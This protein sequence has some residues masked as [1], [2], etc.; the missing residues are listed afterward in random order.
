MKQGLFRKALPHLIAIALFI[1]IALIYCKPALDGQV[2]QQSDI[3]I[4]KGAVQQSINYAALHDGQYPLWTNALLG[5]MPTFQIGYPSNNFI[6]GI[7][8]TIMTLNLPAPISYFFLACISFYILSIILKVNPYV[9]IMGSLAFAYATYNP[10]IISVGHLTKMMTMA[11]MPALLGSILLIY[12]KKYWLGAALTALFS[13]TM[14]TENH[15]Q[16]AYYFFIMVAIMTVFYV[17]SWIKAK[18]FSHLAK[19]IG[20][21]AIAAMVGVGTTAVNVMSTFEYQEATTRGGHTALTDTTSKEQSPKNGLSRSYGLSYSLDIPET[22][23]LMVPHMYG[24]SSDH[25]EVAQDES[26]AVE[27]LMTM[28][29]ELQQQLPLR[30][31]W[32]GISNSSGM[33]YT[34]GPPYA[35]AIICFLAIIAFFIIDKRYKWWIG[36]AL[37]VTIMMAW[38][39]H[40]GALNNF[41]FDHLPLYNKFRAPSM[42][43]VIPQLLLP[44]LAILGVN[45]FITTADKKAL[46]PGFKKG[47]IATGAVFI[48]LFLIY[49]S[50]SFMGKNDSDILKQVRESNNP[51]LVQT[52]KPFFDGLVDDRKGLFMDSLLRSLGFIAVAFIS[53]FL[54]TRNKLNGMWAAILL[55]AFVFLDL[56]LV[57]N[58]YLNKESFIEPSDNESVFNRNAIDNE[59]LADTSF[60]RVADLSGNNNIASYH[61]NTVGGFHAAGLSLY[62]DL[63]YR[64]VDPEQ[65]AIIQ[66]LQTT[67]TT[68]SVNTPVLN[69]LNAKYFIYRDNKETKAKWLN[70]NALGNCWFVSSIQ[71]VKNADEEMAAVRIADP[72]NTAIVQESY[73]TSVLFEPQAD[74]TASIRLLKNDND[75]I[76]YTSSSATNQFA[77]FSEVYYKAG[78]KAFIDGKEAPIVKTNYT[79]R[80]LSVPAGKHSIE[81]R[82]EPSGYMTGRKL[83]SFFSGALIA[84]LGLGLFMEWKNRK[85]QSAAVA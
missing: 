45:S 1:I 50:S 37:A 5:G 36:A 38:G 74:S 16:I 26:K 14:I 83:T 24:G 61:F 81:F 65:A 68:D 41:L 27:A 31:Y 23:V 67:N 58:L 49:F 8:T 60:F 59:I 12:E 30:Y 76:T 63:L 55:A 62:Q 13:C 21:T 57:D 48:V 7:V 71:Y 17:I 40:F 33:A 79:L 2:L 3:T 18:E 10:I 4:W 84:L 52:V 53:L 56:I 51:Q 54:V 25:E 39:S 47:L 46:W 15:P 66:R 78:W 9:G 69:M 70:P 85:K 43:L 11:Y 80:G 32:G 73:K 29:Q 72:S 19:A 42:I 6:P 44:L 35:G 20:F 82:F 34:S 75:I 28:P 64:A 77:V 22:F